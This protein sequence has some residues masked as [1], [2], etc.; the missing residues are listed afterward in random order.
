MVLKMAYKADVEGSIELF[1]SNDPRF[2]HGDQCRDF[3]YVKDAVKMT[4][5]FLENKAGGLFNIGQGVTTTWNQLAYALFAG[6]KKPAQINYVEMPVGLSKQYQNYTCAS[7]SKFNKLFSSDPHKAA[8]S[9]DAV[10]EYVQEYLM[11]GA[12]W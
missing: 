11:R 3:I 4:C 5:A 7:M 12:R 8:S 1:K 2:D 6:L 10:K 9:H